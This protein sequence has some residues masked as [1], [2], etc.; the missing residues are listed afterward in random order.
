MSYLS[1]HLGDQLIDSRYSPNYDWQDITVS[2]ISIQGAN[3]L[4][5]SSILFKMCGDLRLNSSIGNIVS[6][7]GFK[8]TGDL[9]IAPVPMNIN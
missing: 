4:F 8:R 9:P 6:F 1:V 5:Y 3:G 7:I 2:N